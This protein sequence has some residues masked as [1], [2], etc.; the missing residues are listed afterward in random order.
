M[1]HLAGLRT[2][3]VS[4]L[5]TLAFA[6]FLAFVPLVALDLGMDTVGGVLFAA[7]FVAGLVRLAAARLPDRLGPI[8]AGRVSQALMAGGLVVIALRP[9]VVGLYVGAVGLALGHDLSTP[10]MVLAGSHVTPEHER[11]RMVATLTLFIDLSTAV[12]PAA[13]G[14]VAALAGYS[15]AF[16]AAAL[17]PAVGVVLIRYWIAPWLETGRRQSALASPLS[18]RANNGMLK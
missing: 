3:V 1:L 13:L 8:R 16:V 17:C 15:S 18:P 7:S 12:G 2:G 10:A 9:S 5:G 6:G 4:S 14:L 11:A